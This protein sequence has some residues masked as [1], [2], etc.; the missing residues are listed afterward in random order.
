MLTRQKRQSQNRL[1][2]RAH[3]ARRTDYITTLEDRLRQYEAD[4]IHSNVRLQE[5]ARALKSDNERMKNELMLIKAKMNELYGEK[6]GWESEKRNLEEMCASLMVE[7]ERL[8]SGS[9]SGG[10]GLK[11][12]PTV[13][14]RTT[15]S[16]SITRYPI[17]ES[18]KENVTKRTPVACPICPDPDPDCPCQ[19][20]QTQTQ[21]QEPLPEPHHS[22]CGLCTTPAECLCRIVNEDPSPPKPTK[23]KCDVCPSLA[24]CL[25]ED[26]TPPPK[27]T[28]TAALPLRLNLK[29]KTGGVDKGETKKTFWRLDNVIK[30]GEA[31]CSGD[32]SNC[33]ACR[34]DTFGM[35]PLTFSK[36]RLTMAGK[37]F[38]GH[39]FEPHPDQPIQHKK[40]CINC[41]G[42]CMSINNLL[43]PAPANE[44]FVVDVQPPTHTSQPIALT[45]EEHETMRCDEAWKKLKVRCLFT[46]SRIDR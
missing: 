40:P 25:C 2:Q 22:D 9:G 28:P 32:P 36:A 39:L 43:S 19:Q 3:R 33:D 5:V 38:C 24:I 17:G 20:T 37:E 29:S 11:L 27:A 12:E 6:E 45:E 41:P 13:M 26:D 8:R 18:T 14:G 7:V 15:G 42:N 23:G 10:G 46:T 35:S 44:G 1:S 31:V 30:K 34:D 21:A 4:E 16:T